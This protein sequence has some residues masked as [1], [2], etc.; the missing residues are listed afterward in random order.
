VLQ[1]TFSDCAAGERE[2]L[3]PDEG[4]H[5]KK[6]RLAGLFVVVSNPS[7]RRRLLDEL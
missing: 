2:E 3:V 6:P 1:A 5:K 4:G 7:S